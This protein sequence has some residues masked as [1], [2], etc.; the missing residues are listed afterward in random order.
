MPDDLTG[1]GE[2]R[3]KVMRKTT[4]RA[5]MHDGGVICFD[6]DGDPMT[7]A[8]SLGDVWILETELRGDEHADDDSDRGGSGGT[9]PLSERVEGELAEDVMPSRR[10]H[11][12]RGVG[13]TVLGSSEMEGDTFFFSVKE[14][15][16]TFR[17]ILREVRRTLNG[18]AL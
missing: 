4:N 12:R 5:Y 1:A 9:E 6:H 17:T 13:D 3:M 14:G 8:R 2:K 18:G 16:R 10:D 15:R 11:E 7:T